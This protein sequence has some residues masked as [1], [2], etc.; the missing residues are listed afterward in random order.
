MALFDHEADVSCPHLLQL[1]PSQPHQLSSDDWQRNLIAH[2]GLLGVRM[3]DLPKQKSIISK[4]ELPLGTFFCTQFPSLGIF[5]NKKVG[6]H[7][8]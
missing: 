8:N 5:I 6:N 7:K 3:S 4:A 2:G 1:A